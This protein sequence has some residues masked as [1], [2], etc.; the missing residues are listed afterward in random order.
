MEEQYVL[1]VKDPALADELRCR[2]HQLPPATHKQPLPDQPPYPRCAHQC[3]RAALRQQEALH[4]ATQSARLMFTDSERSGSFQWGGR[5]Y[6]VTVLN[7]PSVVESY[8]TL[9]DI[10]LVKTCDIGQVRSPSLRTAMP[11]AI[12][13]LAAS[14]ALSTLLSPPTAWCRC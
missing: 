13:K 10:N 9:D 3:R 8:K 5:S 14:C 11:S 2:R 7:L 4:P 6:P 1:R 12:I